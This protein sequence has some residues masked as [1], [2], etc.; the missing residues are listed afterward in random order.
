[1][2]Y[3]EPLYRFQ[4]CE[5][6]ILCGRKVWVAQRGG[7]VGSPKE[8]WLHFS[9]FEPAVIYLKVSFLTGNDTV[10]DFLKHLCREAMAA[11]PPLSQFLE[12]VWA[13]DMKS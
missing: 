7:Y 13:Q 12:D 5:P 10:T 1:M 9:P 4:G 11:A 3:I 8:V 2:H 6:I